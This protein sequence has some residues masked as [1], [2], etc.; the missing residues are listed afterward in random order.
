MI[1]SRPPYPAGDRTAP[2]TTAATAWIVEV[3]SSL[4]L[5]VA[6]WEDGPRLIPVRAENRRR[7]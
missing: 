6:R 2:P 3:I 5:A 7:Q 4:E 1:E